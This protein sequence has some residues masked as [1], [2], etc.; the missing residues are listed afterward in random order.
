MG[1]IEPVLAQLRNLSALVVMKPC[2]RMPSIA[3][4][5]SDSVLIEAGIYSQS[6][7]PF[8]HS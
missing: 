8:F 4:F 7:A 5:V 2:L 1:H 6:S 3:I